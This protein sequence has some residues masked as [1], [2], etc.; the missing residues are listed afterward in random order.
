MGS[1]HPSV[2]LVGSN[3]LATEEIDV[4]EFLHLLD[5]ASQGDFLIIEE[6]PAAVFA[7]ESYV[8]TS[9]VSVSTFR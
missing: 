8:M 6:D 4:S 1:C 7:D 9:N 3:S 5:V 2:Q